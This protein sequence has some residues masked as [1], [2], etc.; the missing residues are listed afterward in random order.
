MY[1]S[2]IQLSV[3]GLFTT[4]SSQMCEW[5]SA[6][7]CYKG[8]N[9]TRQQEFFSSITI[10]LNHHH[11]CGPLLTEMSLCTHD[12]VIILNLQMGELMLRELDDF[13]QQI[14]R[15]WVFLLLGLLGP[16]LFALCHLGTKCPIW[17]SEELD[18][19][20][21]HIPNLVISVKAPSL[22]SH[23]LW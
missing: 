9:I 5:R 7:W 19:I 17:P 1:Y 15:V 21:K 11:I 16:L 20:L 23:P 14:V 18:S 6:L 3:V 10:L 13:K 4:A 12:C 2:F 22:H 8:Y